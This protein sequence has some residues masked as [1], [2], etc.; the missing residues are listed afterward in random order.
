MFIS[1]TY[2]I[3]KPK[4]VQNGIQEKKEGKEQTMH[5]KKVKE[6]ELLL[7][8]WNG[9]VE[10]ERVEEARME[11]VEKEGVE[12]DKENIRAGFDMMVTEEEEQDFQ[13]SMTKVIQH[14]LKNKT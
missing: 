7:T 11:K 2:Y 1:L 6:Q 3:G 4:E 10:A 8:L 13:H 14:Y 9:M 5:Q 12:K